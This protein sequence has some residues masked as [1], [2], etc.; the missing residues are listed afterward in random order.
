[1]GA[2]SQDLRTFLITSRSF[3]HRMRNISDKSCRENHNTHFMVNIFFFFANRAFYEI[4]W[5]YIVHLGRL[6]MTTWHKR[7]ACWVPKAK[8]TH[9]GCVIHI[10]LPLQ[11]WLQERASLISHMH[12]LSCYIVLYSRVIRYRQ[13][14]AYYS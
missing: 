4:M 2:S 3:P 6:Q 12:C 11:Q 13:L 14:I 10:A 7:I 5:K 8:N 9:A 1:M